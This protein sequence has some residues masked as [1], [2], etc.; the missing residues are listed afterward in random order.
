MA[1]TT[2]EGQDGV[3]VRRG[4]NV[5]VDG[6]TSGRDYYKR[7]LLRSGVLLFLLGL[8]TGFVIPAVANP[9][10]GLTAHLEG[11]QNGLVLLVIGFV[12]PELRLGPRLARVTFWLIMYGTFANWATTLLAAIFG[13]GAMS[14]QTAA[15]FQ[16]T[17]VEEAIVTV[18]FISLGIAIVAGTVIVLWGLRGTS[19]KTEAR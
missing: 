7:L 11:V 5:F 1:T 9:R 8:L 3:R 19:P 18:G 17:Q 13:T 10:M 12:W 16:G 6:F 14:P 2:A 15:G 4:E